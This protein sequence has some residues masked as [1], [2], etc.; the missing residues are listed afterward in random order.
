MT[1]PPLAVGAFFA[2][3]IAACLYVCIL[4]ARYFLIALKLRSWIDVY[5]SIGLFVALVA[6]TGIVLIF[7]VV[8]P[9][10]PPDKPAKAMMSPNVNLAL[11]VCQW[12][13]KI[14]GL[15]GALVC[16]VAL[17]QRRLKPLIP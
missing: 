10:L 14:A 6:M 11:S 8:L 16:F 12:T 4:P 15:S 3:L 13:F 7:A 2:I 17:M 1:L 5:A 9:Q